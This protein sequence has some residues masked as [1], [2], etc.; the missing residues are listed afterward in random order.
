MHNF[1]PH[2]IAEQFSNNSFN[3]QFK[4]Y[5]MFIDISGFTSMTERLM[6]EG[7]EGAEV[8]A[9]IINNIFRPVIEAVH[10]S[11]GFITAFAG[12]AFTA[13]FRDIANA[14]E[15]IDCAICIRDIFRKHGRQESRFGIFDISV[16]IGLSYGAVEWGITGTDSHKAYYFRGE[17]VDKCS[18]SEH[19]CNKMDIVFDSGLMS[20]ADKREIVFRRLDESFFRVVS[21]R[22]QFNKRL[23]KTAD[24]DYG[25]LKAFIPEK[26]LETPP[27][28]EFRKITAVFISYQDP[29]SSSELESII[30]IV[31][32]HA[33]IYKGY[34]EGI[35]SGDKGT[36]TLIIFG[37][38]QTYEHLMTRAL[39]F[40]LALKGKISSQ[41]RIG[42]NSGVVYAGIKGSSIRACYGV[43]GNAV[44]LAARLMMK[45]EWDQILCSPGITESAS[46]LYSF[47]PAGNARLKGFSDAISLWSLESK[48]RVKKHVS[49]AGRYIRRAR[50][51]NDLE[52]L[53]SPIFKNKFGGIVYI[54]GE[55]GVGK[56]RFISN[57]I[58]S[59]GTEKCSFFY[60][61]CDQILRSAFNP[62]VSFLK[63]Y[64]EQAESDKYNRNYARFKNIY[65]SIINKAEDEEL[66]DELIRGES[67]IGAFVGLE[68][69][70]SLFSQLD[71]KG[72]YENTIQS[73]K[74][75]IKAHCMR[76]PLV[77]ILDDV[78]WID[79]DS[80]ELLKAL[81]INV[82]DYPF[83]LLAAC[84]PN[85]DGTSY[86][87]F[88]DT[89]EVAKRVEINPFSR[90]AF[91]DL[92]ADRLKADK[93]EIPEDTEDFIFRK[94]GGN[95]F[96]ADQITLYMKEEN[97][98]DEKLCLRSRSTDIPA[99]ISQI[100][101]ARIDRLSIRLKNII[102]TASVIGR[103][104]ALN[105]LRRLLFLTDITRKD[106]E[107]HE[108][109]KMGYDEQI[110]EEL[111]DLSYI[112]KHALI[113]DSVYG[114]QLKETLR[115]LHNLAG[116]VTE[117]LYKSD[118]SEHYGKLADHFEKA[119]NTEKAINYLLKAANY[120]KENY[121][122]ADSI[123]H[124]SRI[125]NLTEDVYLLKET[126]FQLAK[127][128]FVTGRSAESNKY[129]QSAL[130]LA[131]K[132]G[133]P[134]EEAV[135][136]NEFAIL[137]IK[138][139]EFKS[140]EQMLNE[141]QE[142]F[143]KYDEPLYLMEN[144]RA[145]SLSYIF[146]HKDKEALKLLNHIIRHVDKDKNP[147]LYASALQ[148]ITSIYG[149]QN[150]NKKFLSYAKKTISL[151]EK[152][153]LN[154]I[155]SVAYGNM[156]QACHN[157]GNSNS[158]HEFL[159]K[160]IG[161]AKKLGDKRSLGHAMQIAGR[162]YTT[163]GQYSSAV[164][165]FKKQLGIA[166]E[167]DDIYFAGLAN[168]NLSIPLVN[169]SEMDQALACLKKAYQ[170]FK[171][172]NIRNHLIG[173]VIKIASIYQ[174]QGQNR[175]ALSLY[176]DQFDE[177]GK[178]ND[179]YYLT[180]LYFKIAGCYKDMGQLQ[181]AIYYFKAGINLGRQKS[182]Y[183][184]LIN[185][186]ISVS[187][188]YQMMGK[189][190]L[191]IKQ[192]S[193]TLAA[194]E[195]CS[196]HAMDY[197]AYSL[198]AENNHDLGRFRPALEYADK[199]MEIAEK[200][201]NTRDYISI[202]YTKGMIMAGQGSWTKA[203][204]LLDLAFVKCRDLEK[205]EYL[206]AKTG[207]AIS[208]ILFNTGRWNQ[209]LRISEKLISMIDLKRKNDLSERVKMV[210][211]ISNTKRDKDYAVRNLI[212]LSV[213]TDNKETE[214]ACN[215]Y[216]Y[217]LTSAWRFRIKCYT[218][219]KELSERYPCYLHKQRIKFCYCMPV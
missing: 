119:E 43:M 42:I 214:A 23:K 186:E 20:Q 141:A 160:K 126:C 215:Y 87:I 21:C 130:K 57:F 211:Y 135:I 26:I 65:S 154:A 15:I 97:I 64:F 128:Y 44:N 138:S 132:I 103:E 80:K 199:A 63:D 207:S 54:E 212:S 148:N 33:D 2:F 99:S 58:E 79:S 195:E 74:T 61:H 182:N 84:R 66:K 69:K 146:Q 95:P 196:Y 52:N 131:K 14:S 10:I 145:L 46:P 18:Y 155:L 41:C 185:A 94:S 121:K 159:R 24:I 189:F 180:E 150:N 172:L 70:G 204:E 91:S 22:K 105:I 151:A 166:L 13:V 203:L 157:E 90:E 39:D 16:K 205:A 149:N 17:A 181:Q 188:I 136:K 102:K 5:T 101:I 219:Y 12:D 142:I 8:L 202:L 77:I 67:I 137:L 177:I 98:I 31:I 169:L 38:P 133:N 163:E 210:F 173:I 129:F 3:G 218:L 28:G 85:D 178:S 197:K 82:E 168:I 123:N 89:S 86:T 115:N 120:E 19:R 165:H 73:V 60:L 140:G 193:S 76:K 53:V 62:F 184:D 68:R 147:V 198:L 27:E 134:F 209:A 93:S 1:I 217:R 152:H 25:I 7:K 167:T 11:E 71:P 153:R 127:I 213:Y 208:E 194:A 100:I 113:R 45:A 112:F 179:F 72:R 108:Y 162:M 35:D 200:N 109:L 30:K 174:Y 36:N 49:Y 117:E 47:S 78:H 158:A 143:K 111:T 192:L 190:T 170:I 6:Q 206:T 156:A 107:F 175:R 9:V 29:G 114:M 110:W 161:L 125:L 75:F 83:I 4:A 116:T 40:A 81:I 37:V 106:E 183:I 32:E 144:R 51:K 92:I 187:L 118:L 216:L 56:S 122:N 164:D 50:E 191:A 139:S 55:A 48:T 88:A 34:F 171:K 96:F 59:I 176:F 201:Q 104:F 124:F